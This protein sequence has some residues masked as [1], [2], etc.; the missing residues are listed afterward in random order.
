[1]AV[2]WQKALLVAVLALALA[3]FLATLWLWLTPAPAPM[4]WATPVTSP[5]RGGSEIQELFDAYGR[6]LVDKDR[7]AFLA[8]LDPRA[9]DFYADQERMFEHLLAVPFSQ[10]QVALSGLEE[11]GDGEAIAK[12]NIS[13]TLAGSF[14]EL[15]APERA[16]FLLAR[17][18][19][20]WKLAG[21]AGEAAL[22]QPRRAGLEDFA[23]VEALAGEHAIVLYHASN[24]DVAEAAAAGIDA[25]WPRLLASL[26]GTDLSP[27]IVRVFGG[28]EQIDAAFPG[29]WQEWTG[30]GSR[31]LGDEPGQGGEIIIEAGQYR[32]L[33]D[34]SPG[35]NQR[36]LAHELTHVALFSLSGARTPPFLVEGLADYVAEEDSVS[37]LKDRLAGGEPLSPTLSDL[38]EPGS[39][40]VLL[41]TDAARLAYEISDTAVAWLQEEYGQNSTVE[42]LREFKRR[43]GDEASQETIV[44]ESFRAVLGVSWAD[45]EAGWR[46]FVLENY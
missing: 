37:I 46:R 1:M 28:R 35:Y 31:P 7:A 40:S 3:G 21:E 22:G 39:F 33:D 26:P 11:T 30:G 19:D 27:V 5:E 25:A 45:F 9:A 13:W 38:A 32:E 4:D 8:V 15:P 44:D 16:A 6:A 34:T 43:E 2:R 12:V 29:Q 23:S 42:L 10:Y 14:T 41:S 17:E 20:G 24:R 36:M 18:E